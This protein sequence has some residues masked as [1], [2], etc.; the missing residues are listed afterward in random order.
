LI[1]PYE[2]TKTHKYIVIGMSLGRDTGEIICVPGPGERIEWPTS[3][4]IAGA[5]GDHGLA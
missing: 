4:Q 1:Y 5:E 2:V 3:A